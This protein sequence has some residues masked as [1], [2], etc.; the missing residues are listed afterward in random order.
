MNLWATFHCK[1]M[2]KSFLIWKNDMDGMVEKI[3]GY[4]L[5]LMSGLERIN[6]GGDYLEMDSFQ[7]NHVI[8]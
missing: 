8:F 4:G 1:N 6:M 3:P 2:G 7:N 5:L